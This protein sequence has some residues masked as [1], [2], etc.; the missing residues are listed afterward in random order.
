MHVCSSIWH[1]V[2]LSGTPLFLVSSLSVCVS[3]ISFVCSSLV[4]FMSVSLPVSLCLYFSD[5]FHLCL[6][7][8][9]SVSVHLWCLVCFSTCNPFVLSVCLCYVIPRLSV[10]CLSVHLWCLPCLF[11]SGVF[12]VCLSIFG[13]FLVC[14]FIS[15]VFHV[16]LFISGVFLVCSSLVSSLSVCSS[17]VSCLS[18]CSS[19]V[20]SMSV[21]SSLVSSLS[22]H[23]WCLPCL[24]ISGVFHVCSSLVSSMSVCSSGVFLVC[25]SLVS[26]L[27][28]CSSLVSALSV[29][30]FISGVF[31]VC[32]SVHLWCLPCLSVHLVSSLSVHLWCLP[33]LSVHLWCL[34]CLS[35]RL[36]CLPCLSV[37]SSL[38]S[39]LSVCSSLVSSL[40]VSLPVSFSFCLYVSVV[41]FLVCLFLVCLF[42]SGV[43]Q[44]CIS[45]CHNFGPSVCL[46]SD[47]WS[48]SFLFICGLFLVCLSTCLY[49]SVVWFLVCCFFVC[50]SLMSSL[51]VCFSTCHLFGLSYVSVVWFL[52]CLF[53]AC[54]FISGV[55]R[56][57]LAL[58]LSPF[59]WYLLKRCIKVY[60]LEMVIS[61]GRVCFFA[62]LSVGDGYFWWKSMFHYRFICWRSSFLMEEYVSFDIG[63][64]WTE[65]GV[66]LCIVSASLKRL[67]FI[68]SDLDITECWWGSDLWPADLQPRSARIHNQG[69][70]IFHFFL[71]HVSYVHVYCV[72]CLEKKLFVVVRWSPWKWARFKN[73]GRKKKEEKRKVKTKLSGTRY[74]H[75]LIVLLLIFLCFSDVRYLSFSSLSLSLSLSLSNWQTVLILPDWPAPDDISLEW[76]NHAVLY[77]RLASIWCHCFVMIEPCCNELQMGQYQVTLPVNHL[78][79]V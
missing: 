30:L 37:C 28:V 77:F 46:L 27:S 24:F 12:L 76:L 19:L 11:I 10:P 14:L 74:L 55:F 70:S 69:S 22:V 4:S 32:L 31:L 67:C 16:C 51:F 42:I 13:V 50:S 2:S 62:D 15:G 60:L 72:K 48:V 64:E 75:C 23:L 5:A 29:C 9:L 53:F 21:C 44:V 7:L 78:T 56:V 40:S 59:C 18:V 68:Y 43:L 63:S 57:C 54:L 36:W 39:C 33:C 58:C 73:K 25:S 26:S 49:V 47:S 3:V 41:W 79:K 17:L 20:S 66:Y 8:F 45:T 1:T 61:D 71:H 35:V 52:T 38:V 34:P 6:A 65:H